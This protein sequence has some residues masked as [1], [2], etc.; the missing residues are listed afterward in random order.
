MQENTFFVVEKREKLINLLFFSLFFSGEPWLIE[1]R[2]RESFEARDGSEA[3]T[4][5]TRQDI[6]H[7]A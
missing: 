6:Q 3:E 4:E 1:L 7:G 2:S 5:V